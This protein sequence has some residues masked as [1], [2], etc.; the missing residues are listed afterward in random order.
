MRRRTFYLKNYLKNMINIWKHTVIKTLK[1][2]MIN[3][4]KKRIRK[5]RAV[6]HPVPNCGW[7]SSRTMYL[8]VS[9]SRSK[10]PIM[11]RFPQVKCHWGKNIKAVNKDWT[12]ENIIIFLFKMC[13]CYESGLFTKKF[14][15]LKSFRNDRESLLVGILIW[16]TG[17]FW[18]F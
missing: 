8:L 5:T 1:K 17:L 18:T 6:A 2:K 10:Y 7:G 12:S 3:F 4:Y 11:L 9:G 16:K 14:L 13:F 15:D